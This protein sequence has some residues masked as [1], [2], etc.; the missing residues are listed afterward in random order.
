MSGTRHLRT[1]LMT[2]EAPL[3]Q[4]C[5]CQHC[6][7]CDPT[8]TQARDKVRFCRHGAQSTFVESGAKG[9]ACANSDAAAGTFTS[10]ESSNNWSDQKG[11]DGSKQTNGNIYNSKL[12]RD[13]GWIGR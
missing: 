9:H 13:L 11:A 5:S 8:P 10:D 12:M 2:D 1:I 7:M 3:E 4:I 6:N